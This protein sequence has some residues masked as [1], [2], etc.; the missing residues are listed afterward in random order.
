[1]V[2]TNHLINSVVNLLVSGDMIELAK[3]EMEENN[4]NETHF[5]R[6]EMLYCYINKTF[7]NNLSLF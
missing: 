6:E 2:I 7:S 5:K 3:M 4:N 1:M